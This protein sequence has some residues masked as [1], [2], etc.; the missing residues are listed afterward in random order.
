MVDRAGGAQQHS[1]LDDRPGVGAVGRVVA[2]LDFDGGVLGV[3]PGDA[4]GADDDA[5]RAALESDPPL[6]A[7]VV[8]LGHASAGHKAAGRFGHHF[9]AGD[10]RED[11]E[12]AEVWV[13]ER[14]LG[15][16][17]RVVA[18]KGIFVERDD[19]GDFEQHAGLFLQNFGAGE[20][21]EVGPEVEAAFVADGRQ[22]LFD[23]LLDGTRVGEE[24]VGRRE[25]GDGGS[26]GESRI[27]FSVRM[28]TD[29]GRSKSSACWRRWRCSTVRSSVT[30][31]E[32]S[33][34]SVVEL[35]KSGA[36]DAVGATA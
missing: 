11:R 24:D 21:R 5:H 32:A 22:G 17:E 18:Q 6:G 13:V 14:E 10:E 15:G 1:G 35:Q 2:E 7:E 28:V 12:A 23:L 29:I 16:A 20:H 19:F 36:V 27:S 33:A 26:C 4:L 8:D 25:S 30:P 9:E 3:G 34:P 31:C